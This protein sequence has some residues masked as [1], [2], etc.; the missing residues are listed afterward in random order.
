MSEHRIFFAKTGALAFISHLDF[1]HVLIRA[2]KRARLP[3]RYSEGFNPRPKISFG[4][5]LSVGMEGL[6]E[7]VD[8]SLT[9][10]LPHEEV[11]ARLDGAFTD[12]FRVVRV[13]TPARKMKDIEYAAYTVTFPDFKADAERVEAVLRHPPKIVKHSK[14]GDKETDIAPMI[15]DF[16]VEVTG[17]GT[18]L[19]LT[20]T[21]ADSLYLNPDYVVKALVAGGI[22]LAEDYR[23]VREKILFKQI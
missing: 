4:L 3:L 12:D 20:L 16:S 14:S 17:D 22:E 10:D 11:A 19:H 5:P 13:E 6:E 2:L 18:A 23:V 1:N 9:Q 8:I 15:K 7:I 21:A